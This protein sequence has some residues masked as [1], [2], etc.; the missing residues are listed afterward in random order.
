MPPT[1]RKREDAEDEEVSLKPNK[2][3]VKKEADND[4]NVGSKSATS[5]SSAAQSATNAFHN[6]WEARPGGKKTA[7][8]ISSFLTRLPPSRTTSSDMGDSWIWC[9]NPYRTKHDTETGTDA[10]TGGFTQA[11]HHLLEKFME[12]RQQLEEQNPDKVPGA[13]TR[14]LGP[15]KQKLEKDIAELAQK[16]RLT[17][18][19]WM[20]FPSDHDVDRVWGVVAEATWNGRLGTGSKVAPT[21]SGQNE[22]LVCIYTQDSTDM[23]DVKSVLAEMRRL[24]LVQDGQI[25]KT[26][27]YKCDA[28]TYLELTSGNEFKIKAS[29]YNSRDM[30]KEV[31]KERSR[32]KR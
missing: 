7:E 22:H 6:A 29:M 20:L 11:G 21:N 32:N 5:S 26:V 24:G 17:S 12:R 10:D 9:A 28:Y 2:K 19:K 23:N 4:N 15:D 27:Y 31:A 16:H 13:I 3:K 18:G 30:F 1:T 8:S 25:A 14:M